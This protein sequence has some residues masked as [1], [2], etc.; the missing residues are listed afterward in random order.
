MSEVLQLDLPPPMRRLQAA[1]RLAAV[2]AHLPQY[3]YVTRRTPLWC[4]SGIIA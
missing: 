4:L 1:L 2:A 3:A